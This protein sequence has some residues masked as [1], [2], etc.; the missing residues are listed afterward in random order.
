MSP[1]TPDPEIRTALVEAAAR[2]LAR[3]GRSALTTRRLA[4]AVGTSTMAVYTHFGGMDE[5]HHAVR[6]EGFERLM[7]HLQSVPSTRDP[8]ADLSA[9]GWAYCFNALS[10]PHLYR[11]I[12]LEAPIDGEDDP[13]GR[14]AFAQLTKTVTRCIDAGRFSPAN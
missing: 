8:V 4:A 6:V 2:L 12:F 14:A 11:S 1:K 3:G 10:N 5:L 9:L 13:V 7:S